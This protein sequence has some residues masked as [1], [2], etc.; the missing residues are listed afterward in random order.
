MNLK[1]IKKKEKKEKHPKVKKLS[2]QKANKV[3]FTGVCL[4]V[5]GFNY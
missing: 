3:V 5:I 2:Q 4:L 1:K